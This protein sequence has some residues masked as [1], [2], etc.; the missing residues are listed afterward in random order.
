MM[1][2]DDRCLFLFCFLLHEVQRGHIL[3]IRFLHGHR[4]QKQDNHVVIF[5]KEVFES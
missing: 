5:V 1:G 2:V 4:T 3:R